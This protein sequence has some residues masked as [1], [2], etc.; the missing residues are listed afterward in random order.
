[1]HIE[2]NFPY[3]MKEIFSST[4]RG[5]LGE[6]RKDARN[7]LR[8]RK[9]AAR[10]LCTPNVALENKAPLEVAVRSTEGYLRVASLLGRLRHSTAA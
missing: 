8:G 9:R 10:F 4:T 1:M 5:Q 6:L 3:A 7:L 2:I